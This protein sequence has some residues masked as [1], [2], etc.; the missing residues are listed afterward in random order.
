[1]RPSANIITCTVSPWWK[2]HACAGRLRLSRPMVGCGHLEFVAA[3][4]LKDRDQFIGWSSEQCA[5]ARLP[6]PT[7]S[8]VGDARLPLSQPDQPLHGAFLPCS[9]GSRRISAKALGP[10]HR[11]GGEFCR[12]GTFNKAPPTKER[13]VLPG[14][15]RRLKRDADDFY[16][17]NEALKQIWVREL[18]TWQRNCARGNC[19][20]LGR[21]SKR[22]DRSTPPRWRRLASLMESVEAEVAEFRRPSAWLI[23]CRA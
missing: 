11:P 14:Q 3:F 20:L 18:V 10:S 8:P 16:V 9:N 15:D 5:P 23:R 4:H 17:K 7:I 12:S 13:V 22:L 19:L 21:R 2:Q 6:W 1:M